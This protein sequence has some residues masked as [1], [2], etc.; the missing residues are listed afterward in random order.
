[1]VG[2]NSK[3]VQH[4]VEHVAVLGGDADA[5]G[6]AIGMSGELE[7]DRPELDGFG[8][9]PE[10]GQDFRASGRAWHATSVGELGIGVPCP[11]GQLPSNGRYS[12]AMRQQ[13]YSYWF[14]PDMTG[15][16]RRR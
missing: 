8:P 9:C 10:D 11:I 5:A 12:P 14:T 16:P 4:L 3:H 2:L 15:L 7:N 1:M 13:A 6:D